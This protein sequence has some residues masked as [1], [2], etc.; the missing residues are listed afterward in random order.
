MKPLVEAEDH[1]V[2][3]LSLRFYRENR[4]WL[5]KLLHVQGESWNKITNMP[6]FFLEFENAVVHFTG[7]NCG[8]WGGAYRPSKN[9]LR[10]RI[11]QNVSR[12]PGIYSFPGKNRFKKR[13][14][15][16]SWGF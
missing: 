7:L 13:G 9:S 8:Y 12:G 3:E 11:F 6:S 4:K 14:G 2:T 10:R 15:G 1:G 16:K 5:G